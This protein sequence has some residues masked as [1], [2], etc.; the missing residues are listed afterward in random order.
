MPPTARVPPHLRTPKTF[1]DNCFGDK[2]GKI[3][4]KFASE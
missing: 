4:P 1:P 3:A 2:T